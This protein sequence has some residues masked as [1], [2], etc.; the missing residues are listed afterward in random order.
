[1]LNII[2][3][4]LSIFL[5]ACCKTEDIPKDI[6]ALYSSS[7][8]ERN[9]AALKLASCGEDAAKAVP[10]LADLIY[11]KNVGVQSSAA[12]AL[13]KIDTPEAREVLKKA[14]ERR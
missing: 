5:V 9:E 3:L 2:A 6:R 7:A 4:L 1:M 14:E 11:D 13:R 8:K 12:Y 10:R